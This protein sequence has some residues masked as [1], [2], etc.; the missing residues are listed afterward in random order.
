MSDNLWDGKHGHGRPVLNSS[1]THRP[2]RAAPARPTGAE[3][4]Q[5]RWPHTHLQMVG[6]DN[7][8]L[9]RAPDVLLHLPQGL[10]ASPAAAPILVQLLQQHLLGLQEAQLPV[11]TGAGQQGKPEGLEEQRN[12]GR[13][14]EG[15][16][17]PRSPLAWG[18]GHGAGR[19]PAWAAGTGPHAGGRAHLLSGRSL[20][21]QPAPGSPV[22]LLKPRWLGPAHRASVRRPRAGPGICMSNGSWGAAAGSGARRPSEASVFPARLVGRRRCCGGRAGALPTVP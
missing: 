20:Q 4:P 5:M 11:V 18:T 16:R 13:E 22:G 1:H 6:R 7:R 12:S 21:L 2:L 8:P 19:A 14:E 17:L 9:P 3:P 10:E 15:P